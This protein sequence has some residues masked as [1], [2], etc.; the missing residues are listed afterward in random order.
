MA[1]ESK[2]KKSEL[3]AVGVVI[4]VV[5]AVFWRALSF[6]FVNWD[7]DV[8]VLHSNISNWFEIPWSL[9][10]S[11]PHA[12]YPIPVPT[13]VYGWL[14][15]L[16]EYQAS[17]FHAT[18][19]AFHALNSILFYW[20]LRRVGIATSVTLAAVIFWAI[21]PVMVE[22]VAWV[23]GLKDLAAMTGLL[24]SLLAMVRLRRQGLS[25]WV[26]LFLVVGP[27][28]AM[29]S[30]PTGVVV[31]PILIAFALTQMQD[32]P[33]GR[34]FGLGAGLAW[35]LVGAMV[36]AWSFQ[37]HGDYG[38]Q[39]P[40]AFSVGRIF[41]AM[42]LSLQNYILPLNLSPRYLYSSPGVVTYL[43]GGALVLITALL[44]W[45]SWQSNRGVCFGVSWA[46]ISFAPVSNL[47]PLNRF[48]ADSY[49]YMPSAGIVFALAAWLGGQTDLGRQGA[50]KGRRIVVGAGL[51]ILAAMS[52]A[53][54][55]HWKDS[56][57]LWEYSL[58]LEPD[59][60]MGYLKLGQA[61][62]TDQRFGAAVEACEYL[63]AEFP[64][65]SIRPARWPIAYC[66][67]GE[68]ERCGDIFV[69]ILKEGPRSGGLSAQR[70]YRF[71]VASYAWSAHHFD[72][73][74]DEQLGDELI[75]EIAR[76]EQMAAEGLDVDDMMSV[77]EL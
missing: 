22:P 33:K 18:N 77:I 75:S 8:F 66:M 56:V 13:A 9:R 60:S 47:V 61:Y 69:K 11:T 73:A 42:E 26:L 48:V 43:V 64:D 76:A 4:I 36:T 24:L 12:G 67:M 40:A 35:S 58:Q 51:V 23:T 55:S 1:S 6:D 37:S 62:F 53:Q 50:Q 19:V 3:Y 72:L 10:L 20:L 7:D 71:L 38:G 54:L 49:L 28:L 30:K 57:S 63:D 25:A 52:M 2:F 41:S 5:V 39:D 17:I 21:H 65:F 14:Y 59:D 45:K 32:R 70:D 74:V 29:G 31:G 27:L 68:V 16:F 34:R 15:A 46:A 44:L